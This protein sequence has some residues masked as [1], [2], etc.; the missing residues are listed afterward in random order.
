MKTMDHMADDGLEG[1]YSQ[2]APEEGKGKSVDEEEA[3]DMETSA[4]VP[5]KLVTPQDG[6]GL[7]VGDEVVVRIK[8]IHGDQAEI[9][10]ATGEG[11]EED[12]GEHEDMGSD[13]ELET[14]NEGSSNPG[15]GY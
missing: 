3:E 1:L 10:Y 5:L 2:E 13:R 12:H 15:Y 14:M 8:A 9:V 6:K 11:H 4:L 7:K